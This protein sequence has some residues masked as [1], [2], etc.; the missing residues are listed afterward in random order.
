MID[1]GRT[2]IWRSHSRQQN[3]QNSKIH[4]WQ[5]LQPKVTFN[6]DKLDKIN[7]ALTCQE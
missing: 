2:S 4:K 6:E 1:L 3:E 7:T 5:G